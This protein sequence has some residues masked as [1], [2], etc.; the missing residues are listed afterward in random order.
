MRL[1][2]LFGVVALSGCATTP[3]AFHA[4][5]G[6]QR[7]ASETARI[8]TDSQQEHEILIGLDDRIYVT[9]VD[10]RDTEGNAW[11]RYPHTVYV[12]PGNR[13]LDLVWG[14]GFVVGR[15]C[16]TIPTEAGRNYVIRQY[17]PEHQDVRNKKVFLWAEDL[18]TNQSV[19]GTA[20]DAT[21]CGSDG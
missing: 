19:T 20:Q 15:G 1:K 16:L 4:Y 7:S 3:T 17:L 21:L 2:L 6:P 10:G 12:L 11:E 18:A 14:N 9:A 8:T 5:S 13:T